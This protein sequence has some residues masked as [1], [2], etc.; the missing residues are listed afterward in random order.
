RSDSDRDW[1]RDEE[2]GRAQPPLAV[3]VQGV[4]L[5]GRG[6]P[7]D[8]DPG[9]V[10]VRLPLRGKPPPP[11]DKGRRPRGPHPPPPPHSSQ[12][13]PQERESQ[14]WLPSR[15]EQFPPSRGPRS[16]DRGA[17]PGYAHGSDYSHDR[18]ASPP[19][20]P[21]AVAAGQ[22]PWRNRQHS[23]ESFHSSS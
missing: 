20:P 8:D 15:Q 18:P 2:R 5:G 12:P 17:L 14:W 23:V 7:V 9:G 6:V 4:T 13:R 11:A 1:R 19:P 10:H 3:S 16:V 22:Q 21:V